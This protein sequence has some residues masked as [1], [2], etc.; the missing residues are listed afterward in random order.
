MMKETYN[1]RWK[2]RVLHGGQPQSS[3]A[4]RNM[5]HNLATL[6]GSSVEA[7]DGEIGIVRNFLFDDRSWKVRYLV[8]DVGSWHKRR[9]VVLSIASIE[10]HNSMKQAFHVNC[11]REQVSNSPDVDTTKPLTRQQ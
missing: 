2:C 6:I 8:V 4:G 3:T 10:Q 1:S 11:T 5:Q 7:K 9:E